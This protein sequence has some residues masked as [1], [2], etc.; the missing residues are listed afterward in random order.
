MLLHSASSNWA[1]E[2]C[3]HVI[4][5][6]MQMSACRIIFTSQTRSKFASNHCYASKRPW[7]NVFFILKNFRHF[8]QYHLGDMAHNNSNHF[9]L[10]CKPNFEIEV[11]VKWLSDVYIVNGSID[12][13]QI[14]GCNGW[15][16]AQKFCKMKFVR[17][18]SPF[19]A[20]LLSVWLMP[21]PPPPSLST[22]CRSLLQNCTHHE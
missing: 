16:L 4:H 9:N 14:Y 12:D 10:K 8:W 11:T 22:F 6:R 19:V 7:R 13:E 2:V 5:T 17:N 1:L 20:A 15:I 18:S 21:P 3:V